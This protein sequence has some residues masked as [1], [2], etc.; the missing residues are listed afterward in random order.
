MIWVNEKSN[1]VILFVLMFSVSMAAFATPIVVPDS[2]AVGDQYRLT[3]LTTE[4]R[5]A[6]SSNIKDYNA[7]VTTQANERTNIL[8]PPIFSNRLFVMLLAES[9]MILHKEEKHAT[10]L[11]TLPYDDWADGGYPPSS[12][13]S[14]L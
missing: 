3:F 10:T 2:L 13:G 14:Y 4:T 8:R 12:P 5:N 9:S 11:E 1:V 6:L 7:F